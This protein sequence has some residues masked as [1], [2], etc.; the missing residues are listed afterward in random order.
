MTETRKPPAPDEET[1]G[2]AAK[3]YT[4]GVDTLAGGLDPQRI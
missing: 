1:G 2:V 4:C 3:A